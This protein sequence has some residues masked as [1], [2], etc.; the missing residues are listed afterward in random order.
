M[1]TAEASPKIFTAE[2]V[3]SYTAL[4]VAPISV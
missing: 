2:T 4:A 1:V 3:P